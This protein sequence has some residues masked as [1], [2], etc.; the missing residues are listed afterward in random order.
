MNRTNIRRKLAAVVVAVVATFASAAH[1]P[2]ASAFTAE[3]WNGSTGTVYAPVTYIGDLANGY[4]LYSSVG[5]TVT[6]SPAT[7]G[8]QTVRLGYVY[9]GWNGSAW[10]TL[11]QQGTY[12]RT[13]ASGQSSVT[14]PALYMSPTSP[15]GYYR[16]VTAVVWLDAYGR[17]IGQMVVAP[18][19]TSEE[20]CVTT[21]RPCSSYPNYFRVSLQGSTT[22]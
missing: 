5:A 16:M 14:F 22:W 1:A 20:V 18:T 9:Q 13:I 8:A 7:S 11:A 3:S 17:Q 19:S 12:A 10:V 4:T 15:R 6:R 21:V 2:S